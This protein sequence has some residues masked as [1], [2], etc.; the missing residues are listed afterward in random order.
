MSARAEV[1]GSAEFVGREQE[2]AALSA[3]LERARSGRGSLYLIGGEPGI[4]KS[5]L[6]D[7]FA[8]RA[9]E[10]GARVL[11]GRAWE[12]A[13][14][15]AYWPWI[16]VLRVHLRTLDAQQAREQLGAGAAD[17]A[18]MLPEVRALVP[19]LPP[20]PADSDSARF[21]LFDSTTTF[22][23]N[24][25]AEQETV[26][27]LDDLHA[28]DTP[29]LLLL[30][31]VASQLAVMRLVVIATY[32]DVELTP[33]H[34][35]THAIGDMTREPI[36][37]VVDLKG[38]REEAVRPLIEIATGLP[39]SVRLVA[40]VWRETNG[41]PL[42][43]GEALRLLAAEGRL[44]QLAV[45]GN[46][47]LSVPAGVREVIA[48]R[49]HQ[50]SDAVAGALTR[51]AALGPEFSAETLR[52]VGDYSAD[53][54]QARLAE[55]LEAGLLVPVSGGMGRYRFSHDLVR[56]ALYQAQSPADR[57]RLHRRIAETLEELY[58]RVREQHLAELAH[59]F[60]EAVRGEPLEA[61]SPEFTLTLAKA[62]DY[63]RRAAYRAAGSLAYEEAARLYRMALSLMAL[64]DPAQ[65]EARTETLLAL[66]EAEARAG[67]L[68]SARRSYSQ[69]ADIARRTGHA[70]HLARAA[71][72][73]GG[74]MMWGRPGSDTRLIPLLQEALVLLGGADDRLR[75]LLLTR[76]S[77]AWRSTP[78]QRQQSDVL[79][80]QAIEIARSL[81]DPS[82]LAYAL[83][84]RFYATWWPENAEDRGAVA[85]EMVA[86]AEQLGDGERLVDGHVLI[87]LNMTEMGQ[88]SEARRKLADVT[89]LASELRQ[90]S[91]I[92][93]GVGTGGL[94]ALMEGDFELAADLIA[95]E[96][97]DH[98]ITMARDDEST[99]RMHCFLL[100]REQGR[101]GDIEAQVRAAADELRWYPIHRAAYI[102]LLIEIDRRSEARTLFDELAGESFSALYRDNEWLMGMALA[103]EA[104]HL[105]ADER[106]AETLYGQL[107]PFAGRHAMGHPEG[108]VGAV[109][110]YL[111]LLSETMGHHDDAIRHLEQAIDINE[112]MG[113]RPWVAHTQ[114][115]LSR[116]LRQ[117][118]APGD[119]ERAAQLLRAALAT[120]RELDMTALERRITQQLEAAPSTDA[121]P[122][123]PIEAQA[124][125]FRRE[126]EYWSIVFGADSF[127]LRDAKGLRYLARLLA[128]P[129][130]E[131]LA[132]ELVQAGTSP[133]AVTATEP[134]L[135]PTHL[136]DAGAQLDE[137]AKQ[138]Y[139]ARL[140]ELQQELDEAESWHDPERA[141]RA[142]EEMDFIA[143]ELARAVGLGGRDRSSRS[144]SER[145]RLS[146][147]RAV[148]N[149]MSRI[150]E[151]SRGMGEHLETTIHTG[152]YC[153]YRPDSRVPVRWQ[154]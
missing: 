52:R 9:R 11:W 88:I 23:R 75:A 134:D 55:A 66:G 86:I 12:G 38:L 127:R 10:G 140:H 45:T 101:L 149:A 121:P 39:A 14:A 54:L 114:A 16:Q 74:R 116:L 112:R 72:G 138:A 129:S 15:P 144:A 84:G 136:G 150:A 125:T 37:Q 17:V 104:C 60:F 146:V 32:R 93:L 130:R 107:A 115:D 95:R 68:D 153:A 152:T 92:W 41:N 43:V 6:A 33:D 53:E 59:H 28:A 35:L 76:L 110:R 98:P 105:L 25:A 108:S 29:S 99:H 137:Q 102:L 143:R 30:R 126:G 21:Q 63:T 120:A 36:T 141:E 97:R 135:Q 50:Q 69:A 64:D 27:V 31:F 85:R 61:A 26:L 147:T 111:G 13:G 73:Y 80:Q 4:G 106:A 3:G 113:A 1:R 145:A 91:H 56:E 117:R 90:P 5:R 57:A 81:N 18:Q 89:R 128:E 82:T 119:Q 151:H 154:T 8:G 122:A 123:V 48:R 94:L 46:L 77:C 139:R 62:G 132:L 83:L 40:D 118:N 20:A 2:L 96:V 109:D 133:A 67:D 47:R 58:A 70:S 65:D 44:D 78:E 131:I 51:A 7:E 142:R 42:F 87:W 22:L 49:V 103:S 19:D 124:A 79:S 148:R 71:L 100:Y 24:L 34:P